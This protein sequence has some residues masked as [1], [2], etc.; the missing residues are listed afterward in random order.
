MKKRGDLC[1]FDKTSSK[2]GQVERSPG[3]RDIG[4]GTSSDV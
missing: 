2:S 4:P 1:S 3:E